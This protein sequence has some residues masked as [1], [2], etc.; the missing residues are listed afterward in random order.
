MM[1]SCMGVMLGLLDNVEGMKQL[2]ETDSML[3]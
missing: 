2:D 3:R 1:L